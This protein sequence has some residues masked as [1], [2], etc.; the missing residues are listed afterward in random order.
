MLQI[1][2]SKSPRNFWR[3]WHNCYVNLEVMVFLQLW[4]IAHIAVRDFSLFGFVAICFRLSCYWSMVSPHKRNSKVKILQSWLKFMV[5]LLFLMSIEK[6]L[7]TLRRVVVKFFQT[8]PSIWITYVL[9]CDFYILEHADHW[10][11]VKKN[12]LSPTALLSG[13]KAFSFFFFL[14]FFFFIYFIPEVQ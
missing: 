9:K 4:H 10:L 7:N 11:T 3:I 2:L 6:T 13:N 1:I 12:G 5:L 8:L 14:Y